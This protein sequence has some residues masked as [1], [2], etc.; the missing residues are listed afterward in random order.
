MQPGIMT[1]YSSAPERLCID[2]LL[3]GEKSNPNAHALNYLPAVS[4]A[5]GIVQLQDQITGDL[6]EIK[7]EVVINASGPWIDLTNTKLGIGT[8][9]IGGTKG[10]HLILNNPNLRVAIGDN[11]FF[12]ENADGR[13][14]LISPFE[15]KVL[16]GTSDLPIEDPD[17]A[18][19][20]EE[21]IGYFIDMVKVV[22]PGISLKRDQIVFQ[23][24]GVRP[25]PASDSSS[26]GQIS[27]DHK[28]QVI[29]PSDTNQFP[30]FNLIGG[31][32]TSFRAF[33]EQV[34][35]QVLDELGIQRVINT[36]DV[37]IG[38]GLDCPRNSIESETWIKNMSDISGTSKERTAELLARY[39]TRA[40]EFIELN[41]ETMETQL[42]NLPGYSQEEIL[43]LF[44][45]ERVVHLDDLVLR[46]SNIAK[47]GLINRAALV[48][49]AELI[50]SSRMWSAD[51]I[52][53]EIQRTAGILNEYHGIIL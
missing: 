27:R 48:E 11:E 41:S 37:A 8:K 21:E 35:D 9:Y 47:S 36:Q 49:L 34:T 32:W 20:T 5:D 24:S 44:N 33:S 18:R 15:D 40:E 38:G 16:I 13:I 50:G 4:S 2:M 39:G 46:R 22:F 14:V 25:L 12:F 26:P 43:I 51:Q 10:S 6:L 31:K 28:I 23:F 30:I 42:A 53:F 7:P 3:D 1:V 45:S 52:K 17:S 19:C 29:P